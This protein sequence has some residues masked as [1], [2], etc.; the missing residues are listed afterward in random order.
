MLI[1]YTPAYIYRIFGEVESLP[2]ENFCLQ[3]SV[4]VYIKK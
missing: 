2:R 1:H 4:P 3:F